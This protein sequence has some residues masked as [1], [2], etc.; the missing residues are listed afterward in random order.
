MDTDTD[1]APPLRLTTCPAC[2]RTMAITSRGRIEVHARA[3]GR[4][5]IALC[6]GSAEPV[7]RAA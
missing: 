6:P 4:G 1:T 3:T 5:S 2:H 7:E